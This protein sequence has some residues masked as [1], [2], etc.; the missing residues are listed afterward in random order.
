MNRQNSDLVKAFPSIVRSD[1]LGLVSLLSEPAHTACTFAVKVSGEALEI[2]Y[3][4][5]HDRRSPDVESLTPLQTELWDCLLTRH[6]DG[7]IREEYLSKII[8]CEHSWIPPFVI[9]L[10]GEY[11]IN[12]IQFVWENIERLPRDIYRDFLLQNPFFYKTT[13]QRVMSYWDCYYRDRRKADYPG[14]QILEFLDELQ[15]SPSSSCLLE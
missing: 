12:I 13:K 4:I 2:P 6:H 15:R 8:D 5:Y 3:R 1:A 10:A 11:V 14:F 9:Q 7:F